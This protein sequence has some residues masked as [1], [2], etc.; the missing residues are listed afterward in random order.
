[1]TTD[2]DRW[3]R[4]AMS[5]LELGDELLAVGA[6]Y[7]RGAHLAMSA[8]ELGDELLAGSTLTDEE[9]KAVERLQQETRQSAARL[10][11]MAT[12]RA[13]HFAERLQQALDYRA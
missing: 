8:L 9:R 1:M 11:A 12:I 4:L 13:G 7:W 5:A 3:T 6:D 10:D 2:A